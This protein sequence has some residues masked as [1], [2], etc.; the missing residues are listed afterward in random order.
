MLKRKK[1]IVLFRSFNCFYLFLK[2]HQESGQYPFEKLL[3]K[4]RAWIE[5]GKKRKNVTDHT[6]DNWAPPRPTVGA[7][8]W[9]KIGPNP[10][11]CCKFVFG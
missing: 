8:H 9:A 4:V 10:C 1:K 11:F 3:E 5:T 6:V 2:V 7:A